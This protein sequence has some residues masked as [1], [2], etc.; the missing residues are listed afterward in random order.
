MVLKKND[1]LRMLQE[2]NQKKVQF[3]QAL[4]TANNQ[5]NALR[6]NYIK[7]LGR[8]DMISELISQCGNEE[9]KQLKPKTPSQQTKPKIKGK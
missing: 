9:T 8:M 3:E 4:A 2:A 5:V 6:E 1:L 7:H